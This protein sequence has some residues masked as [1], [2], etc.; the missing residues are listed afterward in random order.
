MAS[1]KKVT[2]SDY[3]IVSEQ[4][5]LN[6]FTSYRFH[7]ERIKWLQEQLD[8]IAEEL[9]TGS[10]KGVN[11]Q[12]LGSSTGVKMSPWQLELITRESMLV[13]EQDKHMYE[14]ERVD[15]WLE[16][17][18]DGRQKDVIIEYIINN[19]CHMAKK[20]GLDL[21]YSESAVKHISKKIIQKIAICALRSHESDVL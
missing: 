20:V 1:I 2:N 5:V 8:K 18:S 6:C 4:F 10:I 11:F 15:G 12:S 19:R 3:K 16:S 9:N 21:G 13:K 14:V 7:Q 17:I